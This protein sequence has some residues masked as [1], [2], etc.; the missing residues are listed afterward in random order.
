MFQANGILP[1]L[2]EIP[3]HDQFSVTI[4]MNMSGTVIAD[5]S[6]EDI[7]ASADLRHP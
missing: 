5:P 1:E 6:D 3:L 2:V 4:D 7:S